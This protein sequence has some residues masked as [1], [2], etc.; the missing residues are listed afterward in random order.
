MCDNAHFGGERGNAKAH[1]TKC[2]MR[3]DD[4][5]AEMRLDCCD[6]SAQQQAVPISIYRE[7]QKETVTRED[8][9][10]N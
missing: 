10:N 9:T 6:Q 7:I 8:G 1:I 4:Y 2:V 3:V 5:L